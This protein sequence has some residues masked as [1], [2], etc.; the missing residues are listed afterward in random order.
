MQY[1]D[2]TMDKNLQ[3]YLDAES[4]FGLRH[5]ANVIDRLS[6]DDTR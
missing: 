2:V 4:L 1:G 3:A 5:G 6:I